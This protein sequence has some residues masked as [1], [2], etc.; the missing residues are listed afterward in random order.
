MIRRNTGSSDNG[1]TPRKLTVY[2]KVIQ[3]V[4]NATSWRL[5]TFF[6]TV[7]LIITIKTDTIRAFPCDM[8]KAISFVV[9]QGL[10]SVK[11]T[12]LKR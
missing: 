8:P 10:I 2:G 12:N 5:R 4:T 6:T 7:A 11:Q 9:P 3:S 1:I